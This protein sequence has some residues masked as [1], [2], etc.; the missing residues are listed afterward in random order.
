MDSDKHL[1]E[2]QEM[3][4]LINGLLT[5]T[6]RYQQEKL[7]QK[8]GGIKDERTA[9]S[10]AI[11]FYSDDGY[12][13]NIAIEILIL[14]DEKALPILKEKLSDKDRNI[15]KYALDALKH[16]KGTESCKIALET[17]DDLDENVVEAA[18]EVIAEHK[19]IEAKD[20]LWEMLKKTKSVWIIN[21]LLNTFTSLDVKNCPG[22][23]EA[24]I[25]S[26]DA[27]PI[28][29][30]I[31]MNTYVRTLGSIGSQGDID[32]IV[33]YSKDFIIDDSNLI[34]GLSNQIV[35]NDIVKL[36]AKTRD[37][38]EMIFK[39]HW[40]YKDSGQIRISLAAMI[41]LN[42]DFFL[43]DI[44]AIVKFYKWEEFFVTSLYDLMQK[45]DDIATG[46]ANKM[47]KSQES[48]L[49]E[50]CLKL[51]YTKRIEGCNYIVEGL[52][53]S[54]N[55]DISGL[56]I[57]VIADIDSYKNTVL[58]ER[59]SSNYDEA[60]MALIENTATNESQLIE[61]LSALF[62]KNPVVG[63]HYLNSKID[64]MSE[65]VRV[66]LI[67]IIP[68]AGD[69][70]FYSFMTT[71]INDPS[72][73]V[74][75][76]TIKALGSKINGRSLIILKKLYKDESDPVNRREI[77]ANLYKFNN[78]YILDTINDA[79]FSSDILTRLAVIKALSSNDCSKS[80]EV[81]DHLLN[82][83]VEEVA[84]AAKIALEKKRCLSDIIR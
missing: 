79:A 39:E 47:L 22:V 80:V 38:L 30:N 35:N 8:I 54:D 43:D 81:L 9:E 20:R 45:L 48:E 33:N 14:L 25:I 57:R 71:M 59:F 17:L 15:R 72:Q 11:L 27:T 21:A 67:D 51:I 41:K 10:V 52:C 26:L 69:D 3:K 32:A 36:S 16:I 13:R 2:E 75:K 70:D 37:K 6:E 55:P 82:D 60:G 44:E 62:K 7:A 23:I 12:I 40:D 46:Y 58:L 49:V 65:S 18:L 31:L 4:L 29:K 24:K 73:L 64:S 34:F 53:D 1:F 28:E 63:W 56:A 68:G 78:D 77:I 42:L 83:S 76:K 19:F 5:A 66:G 84:E 50:V 74:R 61:A